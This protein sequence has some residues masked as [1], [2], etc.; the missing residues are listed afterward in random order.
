M[1]RYLMCLLLCLSAP[2]L[3]APD[4]T[5]IDGIIYVGG[6]PA[7][8]GTVKAKLSEAASAPD[9]SA[10]VRVSGTVTATIGGDGTFTLALWPNDALR[11]S[12][13]YYDVTIKT[14]GPEAKTWTENVLVASSP[15]PSEFGALQR[16]ETIPGRSVLESYVRYV[17]TDPT[18]SCTAAEGP[19]F[20]TTTGKHCTCST[21]TWSC[22]ASAGDTRIDDGLDPAGLQAIR[23]N[24]GDTAYEVYTPFDGAFGSLTGVP[25]GLADG[26]DAGYVTVQD[27]GTPLTARSTVDFTGSGVTCADTGAKTQCTISGGGGSGYATIDDEDTPLTQRT[28][29]NFEGTGISCVDDTDQTTCTVAGGAAPVDSVFGRTGAVTATAGDYT[30]AQV[31]NTPA[32]NV[33]ATT[34]QAAIDELDGEKAASSHNHSAT[35]I[36]SGTLPM[37]RGGTNRSV[38]SGFSEFVRVSSDGLSLEP[39]GSS[40]SDFAA[41]AHAA[42]HS[43][44]GADALSGALNASGTCIDTDRDGTCEV[45]VNGAIVELDYNDD[46]TADASLSSA[47]WAV[48]CSAG[49]S[50]C[51]VTFPVE[52]ADPACTTDPWVTYVDA[53]GVGTGTAGV[54]RRCDPDTGVSNLDTGGGG[55]DSITVDGGAVVDPDFASTGDVD[56]VN[57]SNVVTAN[58]NTGVIVDADVNASA[59]IAESKLA[60][61]TNDG[62]RHDHHDADIPD[63]I[64]INYAASSGDLDYDNDATPEVVANG[65]TVSIDAD[66]DGTADAVFGASSSTIGPADA[67][68]EFGADKSLRLIADDDNDDF[69]GDEFIYLDPNGDGT[70]EV[71]LSESR[72]DMSAMPVTGGTTQADQD[73]VLVLPFQG[74]LA[75]REEDGSIRSMIGMAYDSVNGSCAGFTGSRCPYI[76]LGG[77]GSGVANVGV[78]INEGLSSD[79]YLY[80]L[81][82]VGTD[83]MDYRFTGNKA[84]NYHTIFGNAVVGSVAR[85]KTIT[86]WSG[87]SEA[88]GCNSAFTNAEDWAFLNCAG[89]QRV[90]VQAGHEIASVGFG[91]ARLG[92]WLSTGVEW[93][94]TI[95]QADRYYLVDDEGARNDFPYA[96]MENATNA[97]AVGTGVTVTQQSSEQDHGWCGSGGNS[98]K[99]AFD[100]A[101]TSNG[102]EFATVKGA[103]TSAADDDWFVAKLWVYPT[104]T[105]GQEV[106]FAWIGLSG[107]CS[108]VI[109]IGTQENPHLVANEWQQVAVS[110][111]AGCTGTAGLYV[112]RETAGSGAFTLYI[113]DVQVEVIPAATAA[114]LECGTAD[115]DNGLCEAGPFVCTGAAAN[116]L[117]AGAK[118]VEDPPELI[119]RETGAH[120]GTLQFVGAANPPHISQRY[121]GPQQSGYY[122]SASFSGFVPTADKLYAYPFFVPYRRTY[123][124]MMTYVAT[125]EASTG[126]KFGI[127]DL[128]ETTGLCSDLIHGT[129]EVATTSSATQ[130]TATIAVTLEPGWYCLAILSNGTGTLDIAKLG[131]GSFTSSMPLGHSAIDN[132]NYMWTKASVTYA[133]GMPDPLT[134][135]G[136]ES[137]AS[138]PYFLMRAQ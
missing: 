58:L 66:D 33:A 76:L 86:M 107:T 18:G 32:G 43:S 88:V 59:A 52:T 111:P 104:V 13:T 126:V 26:D 69:A 106:R 112:Q 109:S 60:F 68:G 95:W 67:H 131:T 128:D 65:T 96:S 120:R 87:R 61:A 25:A 115:G 97:T 23:R 83:I 80:G 121:Y 92:G 118:F 134:G 7:T 93:E 44:G 45:R 114:A 100:A 37:A 117:T 108:G 72:L 19:R 63:G 36:T 125:G 28:T 40:A 8:G 27:E 49:T 79:W 51:M 74:S 62:S 42:T 34:V 85:D 64:T 75:A 38:W 105:I 39:S 119:D 10:W 90:V 21:G 6:A 70:D 123:D 20:V 16:I 138:M 50:E 12:W 46:G 137:A 4:T 129:G 91:H 22:A 84:L 94:D 53:D 136:Y 132:V 48:E 35:A 133:S 56:F 82:L 135:L 31:A 57:T 17:G 15:D 55:G 5:T 116:T 14:T 89:R 1:R 54:F 9:G 11:P 122:E 47:G 99:I 110:T 98:L 113:D 78:N 102:V 73:D 127:Y 124:R 24:A 101:T 2:I 41:A 71:V 81:D 77:G 103:Q 3:A 29:L 30:A 130:V